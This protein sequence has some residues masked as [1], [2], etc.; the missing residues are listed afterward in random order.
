MLRFVPF[1]PVPSIVPTRLLFTGALFWIA[2]ISGHISSATWSYVLRESLF[3]SVVQNG[4]SVV[5]LW[6][7][8]H[9][10]C[11]IWFTVVWFKMNL[12]SRVSFLLLQAS[13]LIT[14]SLSI[15]TLTLLANSLLDTKA[16]YY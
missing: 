9:I 7:G 10:S 15:M 5:V 2:P 3:N 13:A 8:W 6:H 12:L 4:A 1:S 16:N 11:G 14:P